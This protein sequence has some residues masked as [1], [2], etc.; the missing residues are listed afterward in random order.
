VKEAAVFTC[1]KDFRKWFEQNLD[2]FGIK[3][4]ILSQEVCPDYV[5]IMQDGRCA[6]IEAELFAVNF[7]YHGHDPKNVDYIV[8]CYSKTEQ[9]EGVPVLSVHKFWCYD[10]EPS[11]PL[12]PEAPLSKD[13]ARLLSAI[14]QSGGISICALSAGELA[15]DSQLYMRVSPEWT[16]SLPRKRIEEGLGNVLSE[17]AKKWVRKYH[18]FLVGAGISEKA[19]VLIESLV[20]RG[21]VQCRPISFISSAFDGAIVDHPAWL[22]IELR[23]TLKAWEYHE[24]DIM[25]YLCGRC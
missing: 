1:E 7:K 23:T 15:G 17:S 21:L 24:E 3:E 22:P 19:C 16:K 14:D 4:I 5:V 6:K 2:R 13:E 9:I 18:H 20:R 10:L 11:E 12:P 25:R 8:A